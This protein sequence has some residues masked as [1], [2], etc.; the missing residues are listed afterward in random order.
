MNRDKL[1]QL[2]EGYYPD[3]SFLADKIL[4]LD[5]FSQKRKLLIDYEVAQL[6]G[7]KNNLEIATEK[8]DRYLSK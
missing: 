1:T 8:V 3:A 6:F 2:I 4:A 7:V 5:S